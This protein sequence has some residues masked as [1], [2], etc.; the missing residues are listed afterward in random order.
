MSFVDA[1]NNNGNN[2]GDNH[3]SDNDSGMEA[4]EDDDIEDS[5]PNITGKNLSP[6]LDI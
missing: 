5:D 4:A 2:G 3:D 1:M 6:L